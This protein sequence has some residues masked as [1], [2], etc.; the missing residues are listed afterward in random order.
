MTFEQIGELKLKPGD[1]LY[2]YLKSNVLKV[3]TYIGFETLPANSEKQEFCLGLEPQGKVY[4]WLKPEYIKS[5][6]VML[7]VTKN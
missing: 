4:E 6:E 2:V 1:I 3:G 7:P 5:I